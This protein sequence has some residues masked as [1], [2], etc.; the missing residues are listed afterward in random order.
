MAT[1]TKKVRATG[2]VARRARDGSGSA[3][4]EFLVYRD[5]G[6]D[7]HWEIV[8]ERGETL[9]QCGG[10]ASYDDAEHAAWR[11]HDGA[12]SARFE[13]QVSDERRLGAA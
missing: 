7:F 13:P 3:S 2:G 8:G 10:F 11:V 6:G 4:L 5:N 1:A 9:A 12:G